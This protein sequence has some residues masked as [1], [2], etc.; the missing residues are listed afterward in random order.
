M[1]EPDPVLAHA[2]ASRPALR[3][4]LNALIACPSVG[5]DPG[6]EPGMEAARRRLEALI[7]AMGF[8]NPQRLD[9]GGKP[10]LYAEH[11]EAPGA[12][13]LLVYA[14]YDVQPP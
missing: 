13:T 11:C 8:T 4:D 9:A 6:R 2:L 10:A 1:S 5:A 12:P 14:H 7:A 3:A